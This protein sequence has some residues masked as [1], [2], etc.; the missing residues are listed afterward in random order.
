MSSADVITFQSVVNPDMQIPDSLQDILANH[1][2]R[3]E[4]SLLWR[5]MERVRAT[6]SVSHTP[7]CVCADVYMPCQLRKVCLGSHGTNPTADLS[8]SCNEI[9]MC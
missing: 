8:G 7:L 9:W 5:L 2:Y 6:V 4:S 3:A 1:F